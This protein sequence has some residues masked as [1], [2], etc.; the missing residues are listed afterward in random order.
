MKGFGNAFD[1][2]TNSLQSTQ[3]TAFRL[4]VL[5]GVKHWNI[6]LWLLMW[7]RYIM[8]HAGEKGAFTGLKAQ[9]FGSV[10]MA[11][12][13]SVSKFFFIYGNRH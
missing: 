8:R 13:P 11:P 2:I 9:K 10:A 12:T 3:S 1:R 4:T 7:F 6:F 5:P